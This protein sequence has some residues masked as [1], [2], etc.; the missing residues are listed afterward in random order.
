MFQS[1]FWKMLR[2]SEAQSKFT[3]SYKK[4]TTCLLTDYIDVID[5]MNFL[6]ND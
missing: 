1:Q 6:I 3:L 4:E 2:N 5:Y